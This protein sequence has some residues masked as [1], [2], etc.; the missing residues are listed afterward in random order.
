MGLEQVQI[1][2]Q[3]ALDDYIAGII[4]L[5][6]MRLQVDWDRRWIWPFEGYE[7]I[8]T[9]A[10][11]LNIPLIALNVNSEDLALVEKGGLPALPRDR[12]EQYITDAYVSLREATP[13][14]DPEY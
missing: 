14:G 5:A 8:F 10:R 1:K 12:L 13:F 3:S 7:P 11:E 9:V 6:E 4:S 2:F